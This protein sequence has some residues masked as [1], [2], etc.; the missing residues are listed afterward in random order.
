MTHKLTAS[1]G[2]HAAKEITLEIPDDIYNKVKSHK[3]MHG[4]DMATYSVMVYYLGGLD[5]RVDRIIDQVGEH[6]C[7]VEGCTCGAAGEV[8]I[9]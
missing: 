7:G 9:Q 5:K 6:L 4:E 8:E 1:G 3:E 2:F